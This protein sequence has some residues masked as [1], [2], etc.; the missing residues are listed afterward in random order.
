MVGLI[1]SV[2]DFRT[3]K[4]GLLREFCLLTVVWNSSLRFRLQ[5]APQTVG[6]KLGG[7]LLDIRSALHVTLPFLPVF[8][9]PV[10]LLICLLS[11]LPLVPRT[12][13]QQG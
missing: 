10:S 12:L 2:A 13:G 6:M 11:L 4:L 9:V 5:V 3:L 8:H 1:L 7:Q